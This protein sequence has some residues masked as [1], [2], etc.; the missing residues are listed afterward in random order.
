MMASVR[1]V[2]LVLVCLPGCHDLFNL[3]PVGNIAGRDGGG[4]SSPALDVAPGC[5]REPFDNLSNWDPTTEQGCMAESSDGAGKLTVLAD[6][7]CYAEL[8]SIY[9]PVPGATITLRVTDPGAKHQNLL[10]FFELNS[11]TGNHAF[12]GV[13][14]ISLIVAARAAGNLVDQESTQYVMDDMLYWQFRLVPS[15]N[16]IDFY[17]GNSTAS[18]WKFI[19]G[20]EVTWQLNQLAAVIGTDSSGVPK[21]SEFTFDDLDVCVP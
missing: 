8:R 1:S 6:R 5:D 15:T 3:D 2:V 17:V 7:D 13:R 14:G 11:S 20:I 9:A 4:D 16:R 19:Y 12:F 18:D 21:I 10:T